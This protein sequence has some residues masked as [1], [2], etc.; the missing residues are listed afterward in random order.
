[1]LAASAV[2]YGGTHCVIWTR[3]GLVTSGVCQPNPRESINRVAT[4]ECVMSPVTHPDR[5]ARTRQGAR[6]RR[7]VTSVRRVALF[8][9]GLQR[10]DAP[11]AA[12]RAAG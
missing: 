2:A 8:A 12:R 1:M 3:T 9:S 11:V 7:T 4:R 6:T 10:S 5:A